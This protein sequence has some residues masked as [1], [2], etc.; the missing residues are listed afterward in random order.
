MIQEWRGS[1][2]DSLELP[3]NVMLAVATF[4]RRTRQLAGNEIAVQA[5]T[6]YSRNDT[7]FRAHPNYQGGGP[8]HDWVLIDWEG[9]GRLPARIEVF[10]E[11]S[12]GT[13]VVVH[14]AEGVPQPYSV[15]VNECAMEFQASGD[16][17]LQV[18]PGSSLV[19]HCY[20]FPHSRE[21]GS[22][23]FELTDP[24]GWAEKFTNAS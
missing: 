20:M 15:L 18:V 3:S 12:H 22:A 1:Q 6:E 2:K 19:D 8:W 16:P 11:A 13:H 9:I 24:K 5:F 14:S 4:A 10:I 7:V 23:M 17:L 21:P